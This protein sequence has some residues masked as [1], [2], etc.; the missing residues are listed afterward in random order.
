[1][2][3]EALVAVDRWIERH[4]GLLMLIAMLMLASG[5]LLLLG[6]WAV[7]KLTGIWP[8]ISMM[9]LYHPVLVRGQRMQRIIDWAM[10]QQIGVYLFAGSLLFLTFCFFA[11]KMFD[12][13]VDAAKRAI[14]YARPDRKE[15]R[16]T[17]PRP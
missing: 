12:A 4:F 3:N 16:S 2:S 13:R 8:D 7:L 1:M 15:R 6:Q 14:Y 10:R 9:G 17:G 5:P 11:S